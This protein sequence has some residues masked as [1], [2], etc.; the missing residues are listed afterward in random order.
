MKLV[1]V[2]GFNTS[3][4]GCGPNV[5]L[6]AGKYKFATEHVKDCELTLR[7]GNIQVD[8]IQHGH[9]FVSTNENEVHCLEVVKAGTEP[10]INVYAEMM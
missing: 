1:L 7:C 9:E 4:I 6:A 3:K 8:N 2:A 5:L 10:F